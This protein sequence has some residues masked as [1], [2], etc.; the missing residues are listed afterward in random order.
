MYSIFSGF[1]GKEETQ[2]GHLETPCRERTQSRDCASGMST[3]VHE[4]GPRVSINVFSN[5]FVL[6]LSSGKSLKLLQIWIC[7]MK[8]SRGTFLTSKTGTHNIFNSDLTF[9]FCSPVSFVSQIKNTAKIKRMK[10]KQLR[11]IEKRDTLA[12]LQK[13][14]K[15]S[16]KAKGQKSQKVV[17]DLT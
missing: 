1:I 2:R 6:H 7:A 13:S 11:K 5:T 10:K 14:Q 15:Q 12:L 16:V 4:K 3:V 8:Q 17:Q 9:V